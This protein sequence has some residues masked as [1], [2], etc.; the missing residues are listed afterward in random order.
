[1]RVLVTG[2]RGYIGSVLTSVLRNARCEVAGLDCN[3]YDGCD[4]GRVQEHVPCFATDLRDVEFT[5]L[6]SFDAVIHLAGLTDDASVEHN[7]KLMDEI[8]VEATVRLARCCKQAGVS[9]FL[10][11]SSCSVYGRG[12]GQP[13]TEESPVHPLTPYAES[14]LCCEQVLARLADKSFS[15]VTLRLG[16]AYGVSPRLRMDT[17]VNEFVG[18]AMTSGR[19]EMKTSGGCWRPMVHVEDIARA[20]TALLLA[21]EDSVHNE[22][23]NVV[24]EGENH[25]IINVAD[26]ITELL[27]PCTR[28]T[29]ADRFDAR[30][31]P[32]DGSKLTTAMKSVLRYRWTLALGVAQLYMALS[33]AGF[34]PGDWRSDRYRRAARLNNLRDQGQL[35]ARLR[36][37]MRRSVA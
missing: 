5:D 21:P 11:A 13:F 26:L 6:L 33:A 9:R 27:P 34:T 31:Y 12:G 14:K 23:F 17:V 22:V 8:N 16:T 1:M 24:A 19:I 2:H 25:R 18:A 35:D 37:R 36:R 30:S 20:F 7:P 10:F 4:F 3:L 29:T 32:T 15:P 28:S